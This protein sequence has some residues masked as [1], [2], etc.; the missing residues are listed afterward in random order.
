MI[1]NSINRKIILMKRQL[2]A[3]HL[4]LIAITTMLINHLGHTFHWEQYGWLAAFAYEAI[5]KLTFPIMAYLLVE[6]FHY[7]KNRWKYLSRF[8]GFWLLSILPF[9]YLFMSDS[10]SII[11]V[12][13]IMFTLGMGLLLL[14]LLEH[15]NQRS[16]QD[17]L[18][19]GFALM[20]QKSDWYLFG[21]VAIAGFW[22]HRQ[23]KNGFISPI[24]WLGFSYITYKLIAYYG[25]WEY[26]PLHQLFENLGVLLAIPLLMAYNGQRGYSPTWVK[27]GFY[28]FYP[29][30]LIIL[31]ILKTM[32]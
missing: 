1:S 5:G 19:I 23:E 11:W 28:L 12:N 3:F 2:N 6:G 32:L 17:L 31:L 13:N 24:V 22:R 8:I 18:I 14:I 26:L 30:H 15:V 10:P 4:K 25:L 29:L 21:V 16:L 20:T 27:W 7:S 9:H